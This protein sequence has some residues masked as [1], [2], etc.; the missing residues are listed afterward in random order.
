MRTK[1][2]DFV[3]RVFIANSLSYMLCFTEQ[4]KMYWLKAYEV[5]ESGRS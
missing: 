1:E 5:P 3:V 2:E 4:G